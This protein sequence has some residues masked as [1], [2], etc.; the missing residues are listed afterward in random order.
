VWR[1]DG[2]GLV[3]ALDGAQ[4]KTYEITD[5][6]CL[7]AQTLQQT[8][9][10]GPDGTLRFGVAGTTTQTL[11]KADGGGSATA[12][13]VGT[14][15]DMD[16]KPLPALPE[17]C[18]RQV[19]P[20]P[21]STFDVFWSTFA[22]NYNSLGRKGVDW[23]ATRELYRPRVSGDTSPEQLFKILQSMIEPFGD[24]HTS[25]TTP[26]GEEFYGLR[27]GTRD[28]SQ[29]SDVAAAMDEHLSRLGVDRLQPY[30][31]GKISYATLPDGRGYLRIDTFDGYRKNDRSSAASSDELARVLDSVFTEQSVRDL[32]GLVI[33]LRLNSG[34][35]DAL[36][37]QLAG[38]LAD[39]PHLAFTKQARNDPRDISKHGRAQQV[40]VTPAAGPRYTGPVWLLTSDSTLSAGETFIEAMMGR[41]PAPVRV[42]ATTQGVFSDDMSRKLP[43]GWTF[44]L[45]NEEYT[46]PDGH[47]Y[48]GE[49]I[50]P[51]IT[52]P[53]LT[54][55][56]MDSG[57]DSALDA[58]H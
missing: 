32:R 52:T 25:I 23:T 49:G 28:L 2:Y 10:P 48:E 45:G 24:A 44:T 36:A 56:E 16:L 11:R 54:Q 35:D 38:R 46:A 58:A 30:A 51:T 14:A 22:E 40:T 37:L 9:P 4:L 3:Y 15:A 39:R 8:E 50:P 43:N 47:N 27:T 17:S 31:N 42:G 29:D 7:P 6:S 19:A 21:V 55:E 18:T 1:T 26:D 33:D 34:G 20:D 53:V 12:H 57:R 13:L 5:V 41:V